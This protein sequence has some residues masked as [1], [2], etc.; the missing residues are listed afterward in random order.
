MISIEIINA[1]LAMLPLKMTSREA[2]VMLLAIGK[3]ESDFEHLAQIIRGAPIGPARSYW[4]FEVGGLTAVMS[5]KAS[6]ET[7]LGLC[8]AEG[9]RP[10]PRDVWEVFNLPPETG[11]GQA[12]PAAFARL[13]LW[14][15]PRPLPAIGDA[16]GAFK[17]YLRNWR[18]GAYKTNPDEVRSRWMNV[19][20]PWALEEMK[21]ARMV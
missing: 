20:Y 15:D 9:I 12:L 14:T 10:V 3:Q 5:H 8:E 11:S 6:R 7:C 19:S 17:Y 1:G 4:Q 16:D 2:V 13:L 18:P 21:N